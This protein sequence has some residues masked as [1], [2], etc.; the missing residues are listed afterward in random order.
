[1]RFPWF[2]SLARLLL[3]AGFTCLSILSVSAADRPSRPAFVILLGSGIDPQAASEP[4]VRC[5]ADR[6]RE[7]FP[8]SIVE[9]K[10]R[11][12]IED[13]KAIARL[14]KREGSSPVHWWIVAHGTWNNG[15]YRVHLK[16]DGE[17]V[18]ARGD[19]LAKA[20]Q[21]PPGYVYLNTCNAGGAFV[22]QD[23]KSALGVFGASPS[24][25]YL[26]ELNLYLKAVCD[27]RVPVPA[28]P[29]ETFAQWRKLRIRKN[30]WIADR[31]RKLGVTSTQDDPG[32]EG[33]FSNSALIP[34]LKRSDQAA[35][36]TN[37]PPFIPVA[38]DSASRLIEPEERGW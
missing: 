13:I 15:T 1:M 28:S 3:P 22:A 12:S 23:F 8:G 14:L 21:G 25:E 32:L 6:A 18:R 20:I 37:A 34:M 35:K 11:F 26:E 38:I 7:R 33:T 29:A 17:E 4:L 31:N 36:D 10:D 5:F 2:N 27:R 9:Y 24:H 16:K 30:F 19:V